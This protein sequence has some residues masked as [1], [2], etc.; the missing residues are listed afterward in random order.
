MIFNQGTI[1]EIAHTIMDEITNPLLCRFK[2]AKSSS[3]YRKCLGLQGVNR[4]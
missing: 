3:N 2:K 1:F 4:Q